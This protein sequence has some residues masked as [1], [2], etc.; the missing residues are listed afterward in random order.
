MACLLPSFA[1]HGN[2]MFVILRVD[3]L[4]NK[5]IRLMINMVL[6]YYSHQGLK[7]RKSYSVKLRRATCPLSNWLVP[8][9]RG[10][11]ISRTYD[12]TVL[13]TANQRSS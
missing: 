11:K 1:N 8:R 6:V 2:Y 7:E 3:S 10:L 12:N 4:R 9:S 5:K 13:D